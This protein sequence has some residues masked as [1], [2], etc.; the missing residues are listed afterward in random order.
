MKKLVWSS[1]IF[2]TNNNVESEY[3]SDTFYSEHFYSHDGKTGLSLESYIASENEQMVIVTITRHVGSDMIFV[4]ENVHNL[5]ETL[6]ESILRLYNLLCKKHN[7][8][9]KLIHVVESGKVANE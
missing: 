7:A 3:K 8:F 4:R 1:D 5:S 6:T 2:D 9:E